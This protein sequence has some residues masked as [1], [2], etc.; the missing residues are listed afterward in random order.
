VHLPGYDSIVVGAGHNGLVCAAYLARAGQ[1]VLL[2][3]AAA[4]PGG[5]V[6]NREFHPGFT[7]SVAHSI[8][9][10]S[11]TVVAELDLATHGFALDPVTTVALGANGNH[12][13]IEEGRLR[14]ANEAD[15]EAYDRYAHLMQR[16]S[17]ALGPFWG[18]TAPR[19]GSSSLPDILT[20]AHLGLRLRGLGKDPMREFM[21]VAS[22][23][24]RDLVDEYFDDELVKALL[25][26]DGLVG[27]KMAPRSPNGA[28]ITHWYRMFGASG[29]GHF[30]P[31]GGMAGLVRA[32]T[33]AVEAAGVDIRCDAPVERITVDGNA[34]GPA[35]RG[36]QLA[37]GTTIVAERVISSADPKTTFIDLLGVESL[38]IGFTNR[39]RRLRTDGYVAKLHLA[40]NGAPKFEGL[41]RPDGR[42]IIAP[43]MDALEFAFDAAKYGECP[44]DPVME[45][46]VPSLHEP[47]LAP[48]GGHVLSAHVMYVPYSLRGGWDDAARQAILERSV[49]TIVRYAPGIREQ[50]VSAEFLTPADIEREFRVTGGHWHHAELAMD[51]MLMMRPTYEA[52]QYATPVPGLFICGAGCHPG[53]DLVG[54]AG[55]NAAQEVLR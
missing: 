8:C 23:P 38:D 3:D 15:V 21:R 29:G 46:I 19:I 42:M 30:V 14:H 28:V 11:E 43:N 34:D 37:D 4:S 44:A 50:I 53:G 55:R 27:S 7:V 32:L 9:H 18:K 5:L 26:W 45:V 1:R 12:V 22:L 17:A 2:L 24:V 31:T 48:D 41:D 6:A 39:I 25:C 10:F 36:V 51:Q 13:A 47:G 40:L 16:F 54:A 20:F 33:H 35:V 49:D 52:A